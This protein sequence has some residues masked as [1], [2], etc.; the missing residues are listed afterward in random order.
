MITTL[1]ALAESIIAFIVNSQHTTRMA[2]DAQSQDPSYVDI[3]LESSLNP[4]KSAAAVNKVFA[5]AVRTWEAISTITV[6]VLPHSV[7][8]MV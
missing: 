8:K 6:H 3:A 7:T 2:F 5:Q 4:T 1:L